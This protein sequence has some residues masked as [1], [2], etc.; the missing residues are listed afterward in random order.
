MKLIQ[1]ANIAG[2]IPML[3]RASRVIKKH[4]DAEVIAVSGGLA[5]NVLDEKAREYFVALLKKFRPLRNM[6]YKATG[7]KVK[8]VAESARG[9]IDGRADI[10]KGLPAEV[11]EQE[12]EYARE[13]LKYETQTKEAMRA[14]YEE[15]R[16]IFEDMPQEVVLIPGRGD[17]KCLDDSLGKFNIHN[18]RNRNL[19]VKGVHFV[20]YG[21]TRLLV[22]KE[23][24][25]DIPEEWLIPFGDGSAYNHLVNE[26][27][28]GE[29]SI[30]LVHTPVAGYEGKG[31]EVPGSAALLAYMNLRQPD[32]MLQG[33]S[34]PWR[35]RDN[36]TGTMIFN[37]GS[38]GNTGKGPHGTF[39][40]LNYDEQ[41][42]WI[43]PYRLY[44]ILGDHEVK[45]VPEEETD[46]K[47]LMK[48][49]SS[50]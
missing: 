2:D 46:K 11:V 40:E 26:T 48:K 4:S 36:R 35:K 16:Q 32:A 25:E 31:A 23:V 49:C 24:P 50:N 39:V 38:L 47:N 12:K 37:S 20:G 29:A 41:G 10:F 17:G 27:R 42:G 30:A 45:I 44:Q 43:K 8:S 15:M 34:R 14:Q 3:E 1:L 21:G 33:C 28:Y 5:G 13:Y 22:D 19:R 9:V 7:G 6:L 18:R